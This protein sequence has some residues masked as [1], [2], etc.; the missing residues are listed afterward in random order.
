MDRTSDRGKIRELLSTLAPLSG[1]ALVIALSRTRTSGKNGKK[2]A[3]RMVEVTD[4]YGITSLLAPSDC[5][6]LVCGAAAEC[7]VGTASG[8][9]VRSIAYRA[10]AARPAPPPDIHDSGFSGF[11]RYPIPHEE[12]R[13]WPTLATDYLIC[14]A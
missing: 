5:I 3:L 7:Y 12:T 8:R 6:H 9:R 2:A 11:N 14:A 10:P 4:R 13:K 1:H